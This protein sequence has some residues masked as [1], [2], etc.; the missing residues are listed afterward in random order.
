MNKNNITSIDLNLLSVFVLLMQDRSVTAVARRLSL[1]QPAVS[2]ALARLRSLLD[3]PLFVRAGRLMDPTP[4]AVALHREIAP[5]LETIEGALRAGER[6]DPL[7]SERSFRVAMSDDVQLAYLPR[8]VERLG[9][10]MPNASL[11]VQQTDYLRAAGMLERKEASLVVGYL[12][13][14]PAA[15]KVRTIRRVTYR[16]LR[17]AGA[18]PDLDLAG[19]CARPHVLV[20]FAGDLI[21]YID[22]GLAALG[23]AR[24]IK[25]SVSA[26]AVL[27][28]VL[29]ATDYLATVPDH[30]A[31]ALAEE[32]GLAVAALPFESPGFDLSIAW[33]A[34]THQDPAE[35]LLRDIIVR[36]IDGK[37]A[38]Q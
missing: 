17:A 18:D 3:D 20:T 21:G 15:A 7:T 19:Y 1:G 6:F 2:H 32:P 35:T 14:L 11:I 37:D 25:L 24:R 10:S 9:R 5:A 16:M 8:I 4:R 30:V 13:Q 28:F 34:T 27:P 12:D 23:V 38:P 22:E 26:F 36:T 33:R 29:Q 31:D